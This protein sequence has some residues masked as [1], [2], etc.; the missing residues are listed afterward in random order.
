MPNQAFR[1]LV[2]R[3]WLPGYALVVQAVFQGVIIAHWGVAGN[4]LT[5]VFIALFVIAVLFSGKKPGYLA[6]AVIGTR[7]QQFA[8]LFVL[9]LVITMAWGNH[10]YHSFLALGQ[11]IA[12]LMI[13]AA[14][15]YT[16]LEKERLSSFSWTLLVASALLYMVILIEYYFGLDLTLIDENWYVTRDFCE[17]IHH[18]RMHRMTIDDLYGTNRLAFYSILPVAAGMGLILTSERLHPKLAAIVLASII[19][20]A[21]ILSGSRSGTLAIL[22]TFLTFI[23]LVVKSGQHLFKFAIAGSMILG[24]VTLLL[25]LLPAGVTSLDRIV[26]HDSLSRLL[27]EH[28]FKSSICKDEKAADRPLLTPGNKEGKPAYTNRNRFKK[29]LSIDEYRTRNWKIALEV[30]SENPWG[31]SGFRT[32]TDEVLARVPD[33]RFTD[34][35]N[36]YLMVLSEAGLLGTLPLMALI[37]YSLLLLFRYAPKKF[38]NTIVWKA[39][40]LSALIGMLAANLTASYLFER[41]LWVALAFA[42]VIEIWS[43]ENP[44]EDRGIPSHKTTL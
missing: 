24:L 26:K 1:A 27:S 5:V 40:F 29:G 13:M 20:F 41:H 3:P 16:M 7:C 25:W 9:C 2:S 8:A 15:I 31:G 35:H 11:R 43:R 36:G 37:L 34:P 22:L 42:A 4:I 10:S 38:D 12:F 44:G 28:A 32:S 30:F 33:A 21:L 14:V 39:V 23:L 6:S 18:V 17:K 19:I